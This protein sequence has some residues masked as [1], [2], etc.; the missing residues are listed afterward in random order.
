MRQPNSREL[1]FDL[2]VAVRGVFVKIIKRSYPKKSIRMA[3]TKAT[4][5]EFAGIEFAGKMEW[6]NLIVV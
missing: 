6:R 5:R 1:S 3:K 4:E 2:L